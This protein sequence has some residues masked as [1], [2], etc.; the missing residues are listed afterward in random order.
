MS[1]RFAVI[2][3]LALLST[4]VT[5]AN[6]AVP[7][8]VDYGAGM[9]R[10][11]MLNMDWEHKC[12][13]RVIVDGDYL[14]FNDINS[15][16]CVVDISDPQNPRLLPGRMGLH[17]PAT[18]FGYANGHL[19]LGDADGLSVFDVTNPS[20]PHLVAF[21]AL[22]SQVVGVAV[23]GSRAFVSRH[24]DE[25]PAG[26]LDVIDISDPAAPR[27]VTTRDG[28]GGMVTHNSGDRLYVAWTEFKVVDISNPD[29][30]VLAGSWNPK[31]IGCAPQDFQVVDNIGYFACYAGD[32]VIADLTDASAPT[33]IGRW[34]SGSVECRAVGVDGTLA[35]VGGH[36]GQLFA[37]DVSD[38]TA[39]VALGE[40][41]MLG[42][43][44][45]IAI[46]G[47]Y[48]YLGAV[49]VS[50]L[51]IVDIDPAHTFGDIAWSDVAGHVAA[52]CATAD[53][54][55]CLLV[56]GNELQVL[57]HGSPS[58]VSIIATRP[59]PGTPLR[60]AAN[61]MHALVACADGGL[62]AFD[63]ADPR[64]PVAL[65][66]VTGVTE[67]VDLEIRDGYVFATGHGGPL[68]VVDAREPGL[69][70]LVSSTPAAIPAAS[71]AI[72]G[73]H[74]F[75]GAEMQMQSLDV[76]D[77]TS[78]AVRWVVDL[79]WTSDLGLLARDGLLYASSFESFSIFSD[80]GTG[81]ERLNKVLY[82]TADLFLDGDTAYG[83]DD[84]GAQIF[85]LGDPMHPEMA[86]AIVYAGDEY[87]HGTCTVVS[88]DHVIIGYDTGRIAIAP[89][90]CAAAATQVPVAD[91]PGTHLTSCTPNPFNP[92]TRI[93]F[94]LAAAGHVV[95]AVHD[96]AGRQVAVLADEV[97]GAGPHALVWDGRDDRD[98][99]VAS[100]VYLLSLR[101]DDGVDTRK[102]ALLR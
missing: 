15:Q 41:L 4:P 21:L 97:L 51:S 19:Y 57:D 5:R 44:D 101:A 61:G 65:G 29:A 35:L 71:L 86:G 2:L 16:A 78:P 96:A 102:I 91:R 99:E 89:R 26:P 73:N 74:V 11:G 24:S 55:L 75:L 67:A 22:P 98:R 87:C 48:A 49:S 23:H 76:S 7:A 82:G 31:L 3:A 14:Y 33:V 72:E 56:V 36:E 25:Q 43:A 52:A 13:F 50:R 46:S 85:D 80:T 68:W 9:H 10:A 79:P 58:T 69:P 40:P 66:A 39:P 30:P 81:L 6:A 59:L 84:A 77:P 95:I 63:I 37:I 93:A 34:S 28:L 92:N 17:Y 12:P 45:D 83:I 38:P 94:T 88:G 64:S 27:V 90:R 8:C 60:A 20:A 100:G 62:A 42:G 18:E 47:G 54:D 1:T 32:L 53:P 70:Q